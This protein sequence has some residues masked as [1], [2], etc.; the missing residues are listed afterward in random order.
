MA[1][2]QE[3]QAEAAK[4][5]K[6]LM[7]QSMKD[8]GV[9]QQLL[10]RT[11]QEANEEKPAEENEPFLTR[12]ITGPAIRDDMYFALSDAREALES[13][14]LKVTKK[15]P[16]YLR[17]PTTTNLPLSTKIRGT[18]FTNEQRQKFEHRLRRS[19]Q[20]AQDSK[21]PRFQSIKRIRKGL[22]VS[23][24]PYAQ[25]VV[26]LIRK[27][28][29]SI[30][31]AETG[32]GK[33]T[34]IPQIL[35]DTA[36]DNSV[37]ADCQVLCV[38][39]RRIAAKSLATRVAAERLEKVGETVGYILRDDAVL[40]SPG[41]NITYCTSGVLLK[42][43]RGGLQVLGQ[44]SH[45]ILDEVHV[46][47]AALDLILMLIKIR[48]EQLK[49]AGA[50]VPTVAVMSATVDVNLFS[51][52]FSTKAPD[53]TL[54]PAPHIQIPGR[55][56]DVKKHYLQEVLEDITHNLSPEAISG[57]I[58]VPDT[59]LFLE[60]HFKA[61]GELNKDAADEPERILPSVSSLD[62]RTVPSG[63]IS[64]AVLSVLSS[65]QTGSI[66]VFVPGIQN[67]FDVERH[68][69]NHGVG[70][71]LNFHDS[72]QLRIVKL[73]AQLPEEQVELRRDMPRGCRRVIIA[74]DIAEASLTI[75][76]VRYVVDSGKVNQTGFS[77]LTATESVAPC[78]ISQHA[79]FQ[80]A[81]RA[82]RVQA[83][84]YY[85]LGLQ[86]RFD[87][88]PTS[89]ATDI[90]RMDIKS[91]CLQVKR[92]TPGI[93]GTISEL[94]DRLLEPPEKSEVDLAVAALK[95]L[96]ALD[97]NEEL[98]PLGRYLEDLNIHPSYAKMVILGTVFDCL[99]PMVI[100]AALE[101]NMNIFLR[102]PDPDL[103]LKVK[104][105][106][107]AFGKGTN[108]PR[109][110]VLEAFRAI[111]EVDHKKGSRE[112]AR[113]A[114][115]RYIN[116]RQFKSALRDT[117]RITQT[118]DRFR[119]T[120]A[121]T[122]SEK[123]AS[124]RLGD[125][126]INQNSE[127]LPLLTALLTHCL[128]P[129]LAVKGLGRLQFM[130]KHKRISFVLPKEKRE[131]FRKRQVMSIYNYLWSVPHKASCMRDR[132]NVRPLTTALFGT[133]LERT[134]KDELLM[135]DWAFLKPQTEMKADE[136]LDN[137]VQLH[138]V[139]N[140]V[141]ETVFVTMGRR[142]SRSV[143][144]QAILNNLRKQLVQSMITIIE[145]DVEQRRHRAP[146]KWKDE[147][148][149][150]EDREDEEWED[151]TEASEVDPSIDSSTESSMDREDI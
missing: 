53:G 97:E 85:F 121:K 107:Q 8:E 45:I 57:L 6:L 101:K 25:S 3:T 60:D 47:D 123:N 118:L 145:L 73:H 52:Y 68:I 80:R 17:K 84:D 67:I 139:F 81:G 26:E 7:V 72:N 29:F 44:Y 2:S 95:D 147:G 124:G 39:P 100:F 58:Q 132:F 137:I 119:M 71:G 151:D 138:K 94:L 1:N 31:V 144:I 89:R 112:A 88:L 46:R 98:T 142:K 18:S 43:L 90:R 99:D 69:T 75:P 51:S 62:G 86:K 19:R 50:R 21:D 131:A 54:V 14:H 117:E 5:A 76:D 150:I 32:S 41:G 126:S 108:N 113:F 36:I 34:Q 48:I 15:V 103:K 20:A 23:S 91:L 115:D 74:T 140:E 70:L 106:R 56:F 16:F 120:D 92:S 129:N 83:G 127:N 42:M 35:L 135:N 10:L 133:R 55:T 40:P 143:Q 149:F 11:E 61:F 93:P 33:S 122:L 64:A 24:Q 59:K 134:G 28:A 141:L 136:I 4:K 87:S 148:I 78:W 102:S 79:A 27:N 114:N 96:K 82:G 13:A 110:E 30:I 130:T 37:G 49:S 12:R 111:R 63:L 125:D 105:S 77:G 66:L 146:T 104:E 22:P 128:S 109:Y 38:Q 116:F 65:T 9:W